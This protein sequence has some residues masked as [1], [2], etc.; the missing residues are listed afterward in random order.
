MPHRHRFAALALVLGVIPT[1]VSA[2][3]ALPPQKTSRQVAAQCGITEKAAWVQKQVDW[4][5]E[6][7]Q[8][9]ADDSLRTAML[10][11]AGIKGGLIMPPSLGYELSVDAFANTPT[12]DAM[13]AS[14]AKLAAVRG[15]KFPDKTLVGAAGVHALFLLAHR[16]TGF[17]RAALHHMM[18]AGPVESPAADVAT[19]EDRLRLVWGRKQIYGTQFFLDSLHHVKL[20]PIEDS[21]HVDLRREDAGLPP[22]KVSVCMAKYLTTG[23]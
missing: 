20:R 3:A 21:A 18:E 22:L 7:G 12:A 5:T 8:P 9:W 19:L 11:A 17:A 2:Q 13:V 14:L 23:R 6:P 15:S 4:F 16:D 1:F 10:S